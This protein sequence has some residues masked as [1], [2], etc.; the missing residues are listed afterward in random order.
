VTRLATRAAE[1]R[2]A[3]DA[4]FAQASATRTATENLLLVRTGDRPH[5]VPL[6][7]V[8]GLAADRPV[9]ALPGAGRALLGVAALRG[10]LVPVYHA[11]T[12]TGLAPLD[13]PP[14]WLLLDAGDEPVGFAVDA[15]DGHVRV[16][17]G[18]AQQGM[19]RIGGAPH[20]VLRLP[21][22]VDTVRAQLPA[23]G[24]GGS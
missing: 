24:G 9:T 23:A 4:T 18:A 1:L 8:G 12:L 6:R 13:A 15:V 2:A 14:R 17:I 16:P 21:E 10:R 5:V 20:P 22:L 11:A 7:D 3:F 19:V